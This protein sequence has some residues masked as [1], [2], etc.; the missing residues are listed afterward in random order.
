MIFMLVFSFLTYSAYDGT[1]SYKECM[2]I[3]FNMPTAC[4]EAKS[5]YDI[6]KKLCSVQGKPFDGSSDCKVE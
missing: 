4:N 5:M 2:D 3:N 1:K 6:G